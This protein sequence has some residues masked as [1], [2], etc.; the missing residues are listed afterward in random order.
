M[1]PRARVEAELQS[2]GLEWQIVEY[3]A[4]TA[5]AEA[6]AAAVGCEI[7]QIVKTLLFVA[8]GRPTL[9]LVAGDHQADLARLASLLGVSRK[10][11]RMGTAT[12]VEEVTGF[13]I[14]G[15]SPLG[16]ARRCDVVMDRSLRRFEHAWVAAGT[17]NTVFR[18]EVERL[19]K[20]VTGQWADVTRELA[21]QVGNET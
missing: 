21:R 5:T 1:D 13:A 7:G 12:E 18:A 20:A 8:D 19:A 14:G 10:R 9:A 4:S 3:A 2:L 17:G 6:A 11:L 16:T 15:V